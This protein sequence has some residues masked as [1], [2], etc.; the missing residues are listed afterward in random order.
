MAVK[1]PKT[2]TIG[3]RLKYFREHELKLGLREMAGEANIDASLLSRIEGDA[4]S[5]SSKHLLSLSEVYGL[6]ANWL[7]VGTGDIYQPVNN[8]PIASAVKQFIGTWVKEK[9]YPTADNMAEALKL[10]KL[11]ENWEKKEK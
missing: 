3:E 1:K 10:L 2:E 9:K 5:P 11:V 6:N 4:T 8:I 7:L